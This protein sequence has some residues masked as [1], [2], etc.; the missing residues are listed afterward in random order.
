[1]FRIYFVQVIGSM[2]T[3]RTF[4]NERHEIARY[5]EFLDKLL[6]VYIY[7]CVAYVGYIWSNEVRLIRLIL[8]HQR[9]RNTYVI[10]FI[11]F[12]SSS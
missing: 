9:I 3:V 7:Q 8:Q 4:A 2:R 1:M 10:V 5:T 6:T 11:N 12:S